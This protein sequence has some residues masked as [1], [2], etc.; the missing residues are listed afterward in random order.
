M[1]NFL[2]EA[3]V[4]MLLRMWTLHLQSQTLSRSD[5]S[6]ALR[7][8]CAVLTMTWAQRLQLRVWGFPQHGSRE[9]REKPAGLLGGLR[10]VAVLLRRGPDVWTDRPPATVVTGLAAAAAA[11]LV[12]LPRFAS[13]S[14]MS[15]KSMSSSHSSTRSA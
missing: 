3:A 12:G 4:C 5:N 9:P 13:G 8:C 14:S 6:A 7:S 2:P 11:P 1:Q 10:R 15:A